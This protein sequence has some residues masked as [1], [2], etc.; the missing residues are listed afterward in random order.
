MCHDLIQTSTSIAEVMKMLKNLRISSN[1]QQCDDCI[2]FN[3]LCFLFFIL[4][5]CANL[6]VSFLKLMRILNDGDVERNHG[7]AYKILKVVQGTFHQGDVQYGETTGRQVHTILIQLHGQ[8]FV[9][10]VCGIL[11]TW[12]LF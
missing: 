7:R 1:R 4:T 11:L 6:N 2:F 10:W 12:I 9:V 8:L 5:R 3:Y